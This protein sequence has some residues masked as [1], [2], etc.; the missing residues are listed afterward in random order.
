M[1]FT[2]DCRSFL[3]CPVWGHLWRWRGAS[4]PN[5]TVQISMPPLRT[6]RSTN[7]WSDYLR[8]GRPVGIRPIYYILWSLRNVI[9]RNW[10]EKHILKIIHERYHIF[11]VTCT[12]V[13]IRRGNFRFRVWYLVRVPSGCRRVNY[14]RIASCWDSWRWSIGI[15]F[16]KMIVV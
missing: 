6:R 4:H 8:S 7:F 16:Y 2:L 15:S 5:C 11:D 12:S 9:R 14:R 3:C 1:Y 13:W 10:N